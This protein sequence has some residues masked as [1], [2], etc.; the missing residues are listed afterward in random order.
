MSR[1]L[2]LKLIAVILLS[3]IMLLSF[4]VLRVVHSFPRQI[5][6][7]QGEELGLEVGPLFSLKVPPHA[8]S[9]TYDVEL[10]FLGRVPVA[11]STV[12]VVSEMTVIP[13]GH[14]VGILTSAD[15]LIVIRTT[16]VTT[17]MGS[18]RS[19]AEVAGIRAGDVIMRAGERRVSH[20]F[21]LE[22]AAASYGAQGKPMPVV[23]KR[24]G[25]EMR[26][27]ITP[28]VV[29]LPGARESRYVL[30]VLLKDP[31]AGVG[32]LTFWEPESG[33]Y[34]ALGHQ[35]SEGGE[36]MVVTD[37]RIVAAEIH[38]I[39]PGVKGRPGEKV[40][41]FSDDR[42]MGSIEK[43]TQFGIFGRLTNAPQPVAAPIPIALN[44]DV[45]VGKAEIL[46]VLDGDRVDSFT[47]EVTSVQAQ[48]QP[49]GKGLVIQVTDPRLLARTNGIVQGMS[50]SPII[51]DGRLIGAVTHVFVN[52]SHRG[53]GVLA[54]WMVYEAG[55]AS[56]SEFAK[57]AH[58]VAG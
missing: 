14:A 2:K 47:V 36:T 44:R 43:N 31:A 49:S 50:G 54:E 48:A 29:S 27:S 19:P 39:Q 21:D 33:L 41:V 9:N 23:I 38:G 20:P 16:P 26:I 10:R 5:R 35:I 7:F 51:Q 28:A 24:N 11:K 58:G 46:T 42:A 55:I 37:G 57:E 15:G 32:T 40:G 30:G 8:F 4:P 3:A 1:S 22:A 45:K 17:A 6:V 18:E 52:D 53:F 12:N 34:G 25:R 56:A 13:A